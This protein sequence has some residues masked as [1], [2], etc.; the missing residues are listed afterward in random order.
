MRFTPGELLRSAPGKV[1]DRTRV[2]GSRP[3][4][5]R[6]RLDLSTGEVTC[7]CPDEDNAIGKHAA[8]TL[9]VLVGDPESF[10]PG[11]CPR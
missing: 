1:R 4:A 11:A 5:D 10:A 8:A 9:L 6:V 3:A 2:Q 7:F